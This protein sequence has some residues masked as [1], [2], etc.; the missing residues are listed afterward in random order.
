MVAY[1][2]FRAKICDPGLLVAKAEGMSKV[3]RKAK[4]VFPTTAS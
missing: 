1:L 3:A 2:G 4:I